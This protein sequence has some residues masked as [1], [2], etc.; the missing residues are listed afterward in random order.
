MCARKRTRQTHA[1]HCPARH[2]AKTQRRCCGP[3]ENVRVQR[4]CNTSTN[5]NAMQNAKA[6]TLQRSEAYK[7]TVQK[8]RSHNDA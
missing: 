1:W 6:M 8:V 7:K 3:Q 4:K 2:I 5:N